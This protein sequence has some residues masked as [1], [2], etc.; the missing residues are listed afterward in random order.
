MVLA[1][2]YPWAP[3]SSYLSSQSVADSRC[4]LVVKFYPY[5]LLNGSRTM[6]VTKDIM[7]ARPATGIAAQ[8]EELQCKYRIMECDRKSYAEEVEAVL[9]KQ[10]LQNEKLRRE[11]QS[12]KAELSLEARAVSASE[13]AVAD[14]GAGASA[15]PQVSPPSTSLVVARVF[16][17]LSHK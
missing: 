12:L 4:S 11:G 10:K 14:P 13:T 6:G 17:L 9:R 7:A 2:T 8:L 1:V 16:F 3:A 15:M 5:F